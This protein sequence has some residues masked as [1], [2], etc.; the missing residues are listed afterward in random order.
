MDARVLDLTAEHDADF[1]FDGLRNP[2][3]PFKTHGYPSFYKYSVWTPVTCKSPS[4]SSK[5]RHL[6]R[7][8][9]ACLRSV[10]TVTMAKTDL[11]QRFWYSTSATET[12]NW[13]LRRSVTLLRVKR[14]VLREP[15]SG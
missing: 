5:S 4:L 11:C 8:A 6:E 12:L 13:R 14:L 10:L 1:P 3:S 15:L 9:S 7:A 2:F